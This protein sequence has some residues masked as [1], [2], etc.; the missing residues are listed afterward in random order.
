[1]Y[2][3]IVIGGGPAGLSAA[4]YAARFKLKTL[5][6]AK[7]IGGAIVNTHLIENWPGFKSISGL[8]LMEKIREHAENLNVEIKQDEVVD[9]AK[10][11]EKFLV[12]AR[13]A[14]YESKTVLLATGNV[15]RKLGVPG[16][17]EFHGKGVSYCATCD[18][19]FFKEKI[20]AVVGGSD[21][22]AK[23]ALLLSEYAT[24]VYIIYRRDKIRAEPINVDRVDENP[25]IQIISNTN[26]VEIKGDSFVNGVVLDR[27]YKGSKEF[28]L[29]GLFIEIG[30]NPKTEL[31]KEL[32][33]EL[34]KKDEIIT[35]IDSSTNVKGVF[36]AGDVID[37]DFK[38]AITGAAEGVI[39]A[40]GVYRYQKGE[41]IE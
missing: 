21:S 41:K 10:Q 25:K 8:E 18:A 14:E 33:V 15:H 6:I 19:A 17:K 5:V 38:Q 28:K 1:M 32:G 11:G 7:E 40:F 23:E 13:G 34:N 2:D 26:V 3:L 37:R 31:A 12:K 39:A 9:I 20:V 24:K 27:P 29:D 4:I 22:A 35:K 16:E 36:A 30:Y